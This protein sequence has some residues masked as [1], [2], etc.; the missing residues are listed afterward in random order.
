MHPAVPTVLEIRRSFLAYGHLKLEDVIAVLSRLQFI[1]G[2]KAGGSGVWKK[3][4][5]KEMR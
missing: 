5:L 1:P 3:D 2:R 4:Y